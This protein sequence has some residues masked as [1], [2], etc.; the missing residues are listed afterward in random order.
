MPGVF[1][2]LARLPM[3][4]RHVGGDFLRRLHAVFPRGANAPRSASWRVASRSS[5]V[6]RGA[7]AGTG[8]GSEV[9]SAAAEA[10]RIAARSASPP[11]AGAVAAGATT[12]SAETGSAATGGASASCATPIGTGPANRNRIA[13]KHNTPALAFLIMRSF[14]NRLDKGLLPICKK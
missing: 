2:S 4:F 7:G 11:D 14:C 12:V 13:T 3:Q 5:G 8:S 9:V 1:E 10:V 6:G